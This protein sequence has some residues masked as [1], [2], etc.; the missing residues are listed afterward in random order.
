MTVIDVHTHILNREYIDL[1]AQRGAP[2]YEVKAVASGDRAV[3]RD[4]APFMT[5]TDGMFDV[6]ERLRAMDAAGVDVGILS[7]TTPNV[8]WGDRAT[9]GRAARLMNDYIAAV[10]RAHPGRFY[11]LASL[12]WQH[13]DD[14]MA[15]LARA[16]D[17][18]GHVG[19]MVLANVDGA[20]LTDPA[21][22]PIWEAIDA[23]GLPVLVHPTAPPGIEALDM[24]RYHLS[25][26][27]CFMIDTSLAVARMIYDGFSDRYRELKIIISHAGATLP[28]IAS[29]L[30]RCHEMIPA[31]RETISERPSSYLRRMYFDAVCYSV[32]ALELCLKVGGPDKLLYG[33]DYPHN[34]GDMA[35]CLARVNALPADIVE[36]VKHRNAARLFEL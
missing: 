26:S 2:H 11:G 5:L 23:R 30:D 32:E 10:G 22:A 29:R 31:A 21:F 28:Y 27:V 1:L 20:S 16:C 9:S 18:L 36:D 14:A 3:H 6:D 8:Y 35:G 4:G 34:I 7:L 33:S 19:V 17:D 25:A 15:E 12:P 24:V 13:A